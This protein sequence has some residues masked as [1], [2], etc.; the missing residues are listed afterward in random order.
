MLQCLFC[1][2]VTSRCHGNAWQHFIEDFCISDNG[3]LKGFGLNFSGSFQSRRSC[4]IC[5][6]EG[7]WSRGRGN[8]HLKLGHSK[9]DRDSSC[10]TERSWPSRCTRYPLHPLVSFLK[11]EL[12]WRWT[13]HLETYA[14]QHTHICLKINS[15]HLSY[16]MVF[17]IYITDFYQEVS[18][19]LAAI[20][21]RIRK[22][23]EKSMVF[24]E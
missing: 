16:Q 18:P 6:K 3:I 21:R 2:Q 8:P 22:Y 23:S 10:K 11:L 12:W 9:H 13:F 19:S 14:L 5:Y 24:S 15:Y 20:L 7:W 1:H 17:Q 4:L